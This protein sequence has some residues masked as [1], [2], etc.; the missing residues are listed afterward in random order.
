MT[1]C[2]VALPNSLYM[3]TV[4]IVSYVQIKLTLSLTT[5][6]HNVYLVIVYTVSHVIVTVHR[7][8]AKIEF[9]HTLAA[10]HCVSNPIRNHSYIST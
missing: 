5:L 8:H 10:T 9:F 7:Y 1:V 2:I 3:L 6:A 4:I